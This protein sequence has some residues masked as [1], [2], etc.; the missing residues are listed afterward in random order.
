[1]TNA[2]EGADIEKFYVEPEWLSVLR[3]GIFYYPASGDDLDE[4]ID[5]FANYVD[6]MH[7]CDTGYCD[8]ENLRPAF[9]AAPTSIRYTGPRKA[10]LERFGRRRDIVPGKRI[11]TH[12]RPQ[13]TDLTIVRR[14]GFGQMGLAEFPDRSISVF[15]HRGDSMGEGGSNAWFL[16]DR[17]KNYPPLGQLFSKLQ[18]RLRARAL[19]V[20]D[21]SNTWANFLTRYK[22]WPPVSSQQAYDEQR[23]KT[24]IHGR[25]TWE[26]VGWLSYR[27]GPT[28]VWGVR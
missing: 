7:F 17:N 10:A 9:S 11:E 23:G 3:G 16:T 1:M 15:M 19:I 28:L 2:T 5:C 27:Y 4:P 26:C 20:T 13:K 12:P 22:A 21:G 18:D 24:Y 25:L 6:E 14:R 8:L